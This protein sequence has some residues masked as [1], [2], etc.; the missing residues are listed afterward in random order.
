MFF[1]NLLQNFMSW[2]TDI[3]SNFN[4]PS[5]PE[6]FMTSF[7]NFTDLIFD[8]LSMLGLLFRIPS[9]KIF[10]RCCNSLN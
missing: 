7:H 1:T 2:F 10:A 9:L 5:I 8:N 3:I 4:L 6:N